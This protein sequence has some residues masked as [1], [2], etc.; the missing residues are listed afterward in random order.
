VLSRTKRPRQERLCDRLKTRHH[1]EADVSAKRFRPEEL[2]GKVIDA[3]SH[4]GIHWKTAADVGFPYCSS[5]EDLYYR[6][7]ANGVD[8]SVVFPIYPV[9]FYDIQIYLESGKFVPHPRP[10]SRHPYERENRLLLADVYAFC[11]ER[12]DHF[13]P[14]VC[15]DPGRRVQEQI[16]TLRDLE[17]EFPIYGVKI[18]PVGCQ[19]KVTELLGP[20]ELFFE[21]FAERNWPVLFHVAVSQGEQFSQAADTF[22]VIEAHPELRYCLAH[23]IGLHEGFLRRANALPNVWVDTA[24][25]KIQ[26]ELA[27]Q[28][29]PLMS[30]PPD[31]LAADLADHVAVMR[32]LVERFPKTIVWG[33]DSPFHSY[34]DRRL[35][36]PGVYTEF[37]LKGTYEQEVAALQ[38][39]T[40]EQQRQVHLNTLEFLFGRALA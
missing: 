37:R 4:A 1:Q 8:V 23:C 31:R 21:F 18:N 6:Q 15:V 26:V 16:A 12:S 11:P 17:Q 32:T 40:P 2:L 34:I 20:G 22:R 38:G 3:H 29:S 25:L 35:Q 33:T 5:I 13:L 10:I 19:T 9:L 24:A 28:S 14:F 36:A 39:L 27:R 7:R 30:L